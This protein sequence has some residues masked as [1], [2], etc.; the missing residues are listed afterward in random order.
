MKAKKVEDSRTVMT[1]LVLPNDANHM[2]N[3]MGGNLLKW[4]DS[5]CAICAG[6]H[7]ETSV[8]TAAVDHVSFKKPIKLG[9]VVTL[10]ATVT[11][12]FNTSLEIYVEVFAA[13]ING[14]NPRR[15]NHAYFTFVALDDVKNEPC[16]VPPVIPLS[17]I[18][19]KRFDEAPK[20]RDFRIS[21]RTDQ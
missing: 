8:V 11:R 2:G 16:T 18:E 13:G 20:R 4:M 7:C 12:N 5:A 10:I 21:F 1:Q 6:K 15:S 3:L 14:S 19:Q 17:E 9:E